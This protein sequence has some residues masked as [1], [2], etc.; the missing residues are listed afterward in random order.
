M[1]TKRIGVNYIIGYLCLIISIFF[2]VISISTLLG[3]PIY[4]VPT[5]FLSVLK[6]FE[7]LKNIV[8]I[9]NLFGCLATFVFIIIYIL[10]NSTFIELNDKGILIHFI[11]KEKF[12]FYKD[13]EAVNIYKRPRSKTIGIKYNKNYL[14]QL[15]HSPLWYNKIYSKFSGMNEYIPTLFLEY[16]IDKINYI[17]NSYLLKYRHLQ[18]PK[19]ILDEAPDLSTL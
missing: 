5:Y 6:F 17:I 16:N 12:I 3:V 1:P 2:L 19:E 14:S 10:P 7:S 15:K 9:L 11:F 18:N 8:L 4:G 13:I